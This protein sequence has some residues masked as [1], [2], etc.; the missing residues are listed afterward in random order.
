MQLIKRCF[1]LVRRTGGSD[2]SEIACFTLTLKALVFALRV[3]IDAQMLNVGSSYD[4]ISVRH[5]FERMEW[6]L[7]FTLL[8]L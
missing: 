5:L 4:A 8:F 1:H 2:D 7:F 3:F 6:S